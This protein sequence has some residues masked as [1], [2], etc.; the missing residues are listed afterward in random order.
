MSAET[1][2][3][4]REIRDDERAHVDAL[5]ST[6][7]QLGGT[8]VR[9]PTVGF[10]DVFTSER[11]FLKLAQTLLAVAAASRQTERRVGP[12]EPLL[13][14]ESDS[15]RPA[16]GRRERC[17]PDAWIAAARGPAARGGEPVRA[18]IYRPASGPSSESFGRR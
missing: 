2:R 8:A 12:A 11:R 7:K 10:G 3:L 13:P 15:E 9:A 18:W 5:R 1:R 14:G 16:L 6:I 4:V 17:R